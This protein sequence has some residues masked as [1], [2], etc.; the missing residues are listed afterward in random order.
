MSATSQP[1]HPTLHPKEHPPGTGNHEPEADLL[2]LP[3]TPQGPQERAPGH[4][5]MLRAAE[6]TVL[7]TLLVVLFVFFAILPATGQVFM[8]AANLR[9]ILVNQAVIMLAAIAVIPSITAG[10]YD[11]S[12]GANIGAASIAAEGAARAGWSIT[13]IVCIAL[14]TG[15]LIGLA[16]GALIAYLKIN[17]LI[18]TLGTSTIIAALVSW[19]SSGS[20]INASLPPKLVAVVNG[21][22]A[23]IPRVIVVV[24]IVAG[25]VYFLMEHTTPGRA[26]QALGSN[27]AAARLVGLDVRRLTLGSLTLTGFVAGIAALMITGQNGGAS[28]QTGPGFTLVALSAVFLGSTAIR[29][30]RFNVAGTVVAVLFVAVIVNG[31]TLAGAAAWVSPLFNGLAL[32]IAVA[33]SIA[34]RGK[35]LGAESS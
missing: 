19:Y 34:V 4:S 20:T 5:R 25:A 28:P 3:L 24:L 26:F 31:L 33:L 17:S 9:G 6:G 18:A 7:P 10:S 23:G 21:D 32:L 8:T 30:G 16:N 14:A 15:V 2:R 1:E 12:I 29:P 13:S 27:A 11:L 22:W 35:T